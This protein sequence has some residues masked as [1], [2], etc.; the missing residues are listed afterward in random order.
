METELIEKRSELYLNNDSEK[1]EADIPNRIDLSNALFIKWRQWQNRLIVYSY[2]LFAGSSHDFLSV[3]YKRWHTW[4]DRRTSGDKMIAGIEVG[5][6]EEK[7]N[8]DGA[9]GD[10][11]AE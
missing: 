11:E 2:P 1:E 9:A 5:W 10:V 8:A 4:I 6:E 3:M 7:D